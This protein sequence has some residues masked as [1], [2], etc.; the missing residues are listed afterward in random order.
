MSLSI[1]GMDHIPAGRY[2]ISA[3]SSVA[4]EFP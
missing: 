4:T 2:Q 1:I 3:P